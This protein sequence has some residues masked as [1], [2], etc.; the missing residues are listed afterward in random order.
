MQLEKM[1]SNVEVMYKT[2]LK[3]FTI[4]NQD[5]T[6]NPPWVKVV[7]ENGETLSTRLLVR[8]YYRQSQPV[9]PCMTIAFW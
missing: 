3:R 9:I 5:K 1:K 8:L 4:P 2:K 6:E 7:L